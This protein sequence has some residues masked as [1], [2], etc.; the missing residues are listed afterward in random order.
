M[1][2]FKYKFF[3][4]LRNKGMLFWTLMFPIILGTL[5][6]VAF[7]SIMKTTE[8]FSEIPVAVV[9]RNEGN[10]FTEV[11][12]ILSNGEEAV[13]LP[14]Y[15]EM[16]EAERML[17]SEEITGIFEIGDEIKLLISGN[18]LNQNILKTIS[19]SFIQTSGTMNTIMQTKPEKAEELLAGIYNDIKIN[20]EITFG[21]GETDTNVQYFYALIAMA[22]LYGSFFG[23]S[24]VSN[25]K[26]DRSAL[27]ARRCISPTKKISM[28]FSDFCAA[29][30]LLFIIVL[31]ILVYIIFVL[32]INFGDVW[33]YVILTAFVGCITGV[34]FGTLVASVLKTDDKTTEGILSAASTFLCFLSGL[35]LGNMKYVIEQYAPLINRIN[36]AALLSDAFYCLAVY[37]NYSRYTLNII[38]LLVISAI[39]CIASAIILG[40]KKYAGI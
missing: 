12:K 33:G 16:Q 29:V 6:N 8:S 32:N 38:S 15:V 23:G 26:A 10:Y 7:G 28:I 18:G 21:K 31:I 35:M 39:F 27:A 3:V 9:V 22:C 37:D 5:F 24:N 40:R 13:L 14:E 4:L 34:G 19:D 1:V 11:L 2:Q 36:P 30:I 25:I 17:A 20:H